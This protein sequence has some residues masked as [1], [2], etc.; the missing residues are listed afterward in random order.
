MQQKEQNIKFLYKSRICIRNNAVPIGYEI[1]QFPPIFPISPNF[2]VIG[3]ITK[4]KKKVQRNIQD[5]FKICL[6]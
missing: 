6:H 4:T 1:S 5:G 3:T 2:P